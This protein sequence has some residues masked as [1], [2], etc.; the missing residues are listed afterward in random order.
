[1]FLDSCYLR[2]ITQIDTEKTFIWRNDKEIISGLCSPFRYVN[3]ETEEQWFLNYQNNRSSQVR[4]GIIDKHSNQIIGMVSLLQIDFISQTA[5]FAL[6]IG[7]KNFWNKGIGKWATKNMI[8]H[9]FKNLNLNRISLYV[10]CENISAKKIYESVGFKKEGTL[11]QAIFK[12]GEHK[13]LILMSI[14]KEEFKL[15]NQELEASELC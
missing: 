11:R 15:S 1:M 5:E 6:Q 3:L 9:G 4:L 13:D 2:E 14:L 10:L 8:I 7:D 12:S